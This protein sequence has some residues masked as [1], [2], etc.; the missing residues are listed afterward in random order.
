MTLTAQ[1]G[2]EIA[3]EATVR[4]RQLEDAVVAVVA[5]R[6]HLEDLDRECVQLAQHGYWS[7]SITGAVEEAE[8]RAAAILAELKLGRESSGMTYPRLAAD[9][10]HPLPADGEVT[11]YHDPAEKRVP[12]M[13]R[14][15]GEAWARYGQWV[16]AWVGKAPKKIT[17]PATDEAPHFRSGKRVLQGSDSARKS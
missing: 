2:E 1:R 12:P 15:S 7:P 10:L 3:A 6:A 16:V 13:T 5:L 8:Q 11:I 14:G 9:H 17:L 4:I